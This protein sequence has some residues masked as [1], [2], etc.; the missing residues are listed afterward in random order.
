MLTSVSFKMPVLKMVTLELRLT[1]EESRYCT[2]NR[3]FYTVLNSYV[4]LHPI[5]TAWAK[6]NDV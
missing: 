4:T 1:Y 3:F 6:L 5:I 2:G